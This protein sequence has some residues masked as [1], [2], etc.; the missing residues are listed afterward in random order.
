MLIENTLTFLSLT[1]VRHGQTDGNANNRFEGFIDTPLNYNGCRQAKSAGAW[2][3]NDVFDLNS[4][5]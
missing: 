3:S 2:L 5:L 4:Q 1:V